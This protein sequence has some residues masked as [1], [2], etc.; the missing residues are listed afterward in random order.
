MSSRPTSIKS[1]PLIVKQNIGRT[2]IFPT[3]LQ[4]RSGP[5]T[6]TLINYLMPVAPVRAS[7]EVPSWSPSGI[8]TTSQQHAF[9]VNSSSTPTPTLRAQGEEASAWSCV[10]HFLLLESHG[11]YVTHGDCAGFG[12][13]H[14]CGCQST[15]PFRGIQSDGPG[16]CS[17]KDG[18]YFTYYLSDENQEW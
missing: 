7:P 9:P 8:S 4:W 14:D 18:A 11:T 17:L 6:A 13:S 12:Q 1:K 5:L 16:L 2:L 15:N 3:C 10:R